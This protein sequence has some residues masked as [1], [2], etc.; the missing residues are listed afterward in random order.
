MPVEVTAG[1]LFFPDQPPLP[2]SSV[3]PVAPPFKS[4]LF[5]A[6]IRWLFTVWRVRSGNLLFNDRA[7]SARFIPIVLA[8]LDAIELN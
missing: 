6:R 5:A 4:Q 8:P 1:A 3:S 2:F 7:T